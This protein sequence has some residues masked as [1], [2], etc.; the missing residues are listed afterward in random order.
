V[1]SGNAVYAVVA[2]LSLPR[3]NR[4]GAVRR[5]RAIGLTLSLGLSSAVAQAPDAHPKPTE[6]VIRRYEKLIADGALLSP[7]GWKRAS[8][9]FERSDPYP[10]NGEIQIVS[11][12]GS[13][14]ENWMRGDEAE[15]GTTWNDF[16]GTIGAH[17]RYKP[18]AYDGSI[19]MGQIFPMVRTHSES[20]TNERN[21]ATDPMV[22]GE[23]KIKAT[24]RVRFARI[25]WRLSTWKTCVTTHKIR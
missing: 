25:Q 18:P 15:V 10:R 5:S 21:K 12:G 13:V 19:M 1:Y 20:G 11:T 22:A 17:L 7:E 23:W 16:Y 24:Q 2:K 14:G 4:L 9:L 3:W 6:L 8:R